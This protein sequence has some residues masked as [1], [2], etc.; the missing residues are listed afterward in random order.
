MTHARKKWWSYS[1]G[2]RGKNRVRAFEHGET[3]RLFLEFTD[4]GKRRRV[5]LGDRDRNVVKAKAEELAAAL[6]REEP[7][8]RRI[9]LSKL[10]DIYLGEVTP[11]KGVNS[12][13]HDRGA[14]RRL[15]ACFGPHRSVA[16]L[17][18]RDWDAFIGW[19]R[20]GGD[21]RE[22]RTQG[23]PVRARAVERDLRFLHAVL[24]WA[25]TARAGH[26]GFLLDRNPLK[27]MPWPK[28]SD[29]RRPMLT[30]GEYQA[31]RG[32][33][34]DIDALFEL[35]LILAH[36]TGH[37]IGAIAQL[38]WSDVDLAGKR[39]RWRG[40]TD[41]IRFPHETMLTPEAASALECART[42]C[43]SI[44]AVWIFPAPKDPTR[45]CSRHLFRD[46][47]RRAEARAGITRIPGRGWHSL[48][49]KFATE[50]KHMPL[51]D[52]AALG[53]WKWPMTLLLCY[54][55]PDEETQLAALAS[56]RPLKRHRE[57]TPPAA[58]G[59]KRNSR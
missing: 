8:V 21:V 4:G 31:L 39:I 25:T 51:R 47:W 28:E 2:E 29:P 49:R 1:T 26:G 42:R 53:G 55:Q 57:S 17:N 33:A 36:E 56:R 24:N 5:A 38:R 16:T 54:Q 27:G 13:C 23:Q 12:R 19:R 14:S 46:W 7:P 3:G 15:V 43:P 18:R 48:R 32:I 10:F 59:R 58:S 34:G 45:P 41:K 22:G 20:R 35:A 11:Q 9:T 44:G 40:E 37:R 6:R 50:L 30:D 52:L